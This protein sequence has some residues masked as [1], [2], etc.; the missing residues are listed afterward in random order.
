MT[1]YCTL[2]RSYDHRIKPRIVRQTLLTGKEGAAVSDWFN[3]IGSAL[4]VRPLSATAI[5]LAA[6]ADIHS[7]DRFSHLRVAF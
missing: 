3:W 6:N 2:P 7:V 4:M 5:A 1:S